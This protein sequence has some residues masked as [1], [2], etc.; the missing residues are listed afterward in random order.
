MRER[1]QSL[2]DEVI[3]LV[4]GCCPAFKTEDNPFGIKSLEMQSR[5]RR[6]LIQDEEGVVLMIQKA[7]PMAPEKNQRKREKKKKVGT[8]GS[9]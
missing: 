8:K 7:V 6:D 3:G 2:L 5:R 9:G 4:G 1:I